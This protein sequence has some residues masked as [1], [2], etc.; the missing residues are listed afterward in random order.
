MGNRGY[1]GIGIW[2][3][4]TLVVVR[5]CGGNVGLTLPASVGF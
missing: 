4:G 5:D 2:E 1:K 3:V